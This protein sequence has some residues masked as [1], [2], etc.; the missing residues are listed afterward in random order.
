MMAEQRKAWWQEQLRA[1]T[2][3]YKQ[4][5]E[6]A[7]WVWCEHYEISNPLQVMTYFS[8]KTFPHTPTLSHQ[9]GTSYQMSVTS[10]GP[11]KVLHEHRW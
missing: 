7:H 5:A 3:I 4:K 8:S 9:L 11:H 10:G 1:H 2:P 6:R